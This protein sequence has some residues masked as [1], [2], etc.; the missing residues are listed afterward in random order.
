VAA[1]AIDRAVL[2]LMNPFLEESRPKFIEAEY[3]W[4]PLIAI[5]LISD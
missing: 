4:R 2:T 3:Q 1:P 5:L